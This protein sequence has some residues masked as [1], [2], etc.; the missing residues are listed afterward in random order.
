MRVL[1]A[2]L[3]RNCGHGFLAP[4]I[5]RSGSRELFKKWSPFGD[6]LLIL[7]AHLQ[8]LIDKFKPDILG[9]ARPFT[10]RGDTPMNLLPMYGGF[11]IMHRLAATNHL[12]I[13][14]IQE[15]DARLM[16]LGKG[17]MP[18]KSAALKLAINRACKARNWPACNEEASDA[19]CIAAAV[20]EKRQPSRAHQTTPLFATAPRAR[21]KK[22]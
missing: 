14:I 5:V 17:N 2:D 1:G 16:M 6:A 15:S 21:R 7:E 3:G 12:P 13:E 22:P 11:A 4:G 19:L 9:V 20:L 10:R 8:G 18:N